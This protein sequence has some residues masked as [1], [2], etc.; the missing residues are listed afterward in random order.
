MSLRISSAPAQVG[1]FAAALAGCAAE[2]PPPPGDTIDCAIGGEAELAAACT[3]ETIAG[4][5][6]FV[7]HHPDGGFRRFTRDPATGA[8]VPVD[9]SAPL[10]SQSG[11]GGALQFAVEADRYRIPRELLAAGPE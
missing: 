9:G 2:S 11:E 1:A 8:V 6:D 3:L 7:I 10:V 5:T 4:S